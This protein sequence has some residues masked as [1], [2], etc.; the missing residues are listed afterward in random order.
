MGRRK[1]FFPDLVW[2]LAGVTQSYS[3]MTKA[4]KC[5]PNY[6]GK[7]KKLI[8]KILI[9]DLLQPFPYLKIQ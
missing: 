3:P 5:C 8:T 7:K 2:N 1:A 9:E 4:L 6:V